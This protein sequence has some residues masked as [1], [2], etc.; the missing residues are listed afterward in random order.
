[1][2]VQNKMKIMFQIH[3]SSSSKILMLNTEDF[4]YSFSIEN[5]TSLIHCKIKKVVYKMMFNKTSK[6][7]EYTNK[8]MRRFVNDASE[9][10][11]FLFEK[12]LQKRIQSTQF[13]S[14]ITIVM[15][16][17]DKKNYFNAKIYKSIVLLDMLSKILKFII[18]KCLQNIIEAC[19]LI[20][21]IQIKAC[22]HRSIDTTLQLIIEK[23]YIV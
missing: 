10:I 12:C 8:I 22:K 17:S 7:T 21:N 6:H 5:D 16:K 19:N 4:K 11:H 14:V 15:Q 20:L 9:Q 18:F 13:K 3:F 23:I 2:T 1:M